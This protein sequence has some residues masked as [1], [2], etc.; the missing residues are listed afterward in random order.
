[1]PAQPTPITSLECIPRLY[2]SQRARIASWPVPPSFK[3]GNKVYPSY[4]AQTAKDCNSWNVP[5][6]DIVKNVTV[7][8]GTLES[9]FY[10]PV[11]RGESDALSPG[12]IH[13]QAR[14]LITIWIPR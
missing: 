13:V 8:K 5:V 2:A 6:K 12:G 9:Y 1:M 11:L 4:K 14:L 3:R 10:G 7:E